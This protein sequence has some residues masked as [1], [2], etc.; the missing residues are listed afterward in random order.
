MLDNYE[1]DK[2]GVIHQTRYE[3]YNY[4]LKYVHD[5]YDAYGELTK[6]MS[7]LRLGYIIGVINRFPKTI[8]DIGYGNGDFLKTCSN[9]VPE[10]YGHDVSNYPIPENCKLIDDIFTNAFDVITFFDSLEHYEDINFISKLK[11]SYIVISLPWCHY[12]SDEWFRIWK[13]RR[14]NEHLHHFS[15]EALT[16][17]M[18]ANGYECISLTN[19]ED[20]IRKP[21]DGNKNILT[22]IFKKIE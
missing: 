7:H 13:H 19:I 5:R 8:L 16:N 21:N 2:Y 18:S 20:I 12:F 9:V 10:C 15:E 6:R 1:K 11:C 14:E 22:G 17:F 3:K 4:D